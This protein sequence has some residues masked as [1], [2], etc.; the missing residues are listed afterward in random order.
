MSGVK[1]ASALGFSLEVGP[2]AK[3]KPACPDILC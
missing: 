3:I 1:G 2:G